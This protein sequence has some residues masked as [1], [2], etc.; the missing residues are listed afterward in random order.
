[1][2]GPIGGHTPES[3]RMLLYLIRFMVGVTVLMVT[4]FGVV[5]IAWATKN[6][7]PATVIIVFIILAYF[8]G[9]KVLPE[10]GD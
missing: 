10:Y 7:G 6:L 5:F 3:L 2:T 8:I 1:M 4:A 9:K